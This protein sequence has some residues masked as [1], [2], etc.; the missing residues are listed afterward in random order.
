MSL[1]WF[2]VASGF[3]RHPKTLKLCTLVGDPNAGMY[4]VRLMEYCAEFA[5]TGEIPSEMIERAAGWHRVRSPG[6]LLRSMVEVGFLEPRGLHHFLH[7][8]DERNGAHVRKAA[9][10]NAR[11]NASRRNPDKTPRG[12]SAGPRAGEESRVEDK[13]LLPAAA[14]SGNRKAKKETDPRFA[15]LRAIWEEEFRAV[16]HGVKYHW[17]GAADAAG[18]HRV[19]TTDPEEFRRR[20]RAALQANGFKHSASVAKL[21]SSEVWNDLAGTL[22]RLPQSPARWWLSLTAEAR[23]RYLAERRAIDPSLDDAPFGATGEAHAA[24]MESLNQRWASEAR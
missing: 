1:P 20:A 3:S 16:H 8:W 7:G 17:S 21:T 19:I 15:P 2:A 23:S 6:K 5:P 24:E 13:L 22:D 18:I 11:P 4:V 14:A 10:D 9:K 12:V